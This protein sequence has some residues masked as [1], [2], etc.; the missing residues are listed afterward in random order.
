LTG[1][2]ERELPESRRGY[3]GAETVDNFPWIWNQFKGKSVD[4]IFEMK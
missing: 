2:T 4:R 1:Q 3:A